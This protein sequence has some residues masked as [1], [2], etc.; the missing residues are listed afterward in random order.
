LGR[1]EDAR[2]AWET[3]AGQQTSKDPKRAFVTV[4]PTQD[5]YVLKCRTALEVLK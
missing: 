2:K 3:G 1:A 4:T 5:E